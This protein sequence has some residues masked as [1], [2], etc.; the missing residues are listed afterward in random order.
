MSLVFVGSCTA[1]HH[2]CFKMVDMLI[3]HFEMNMKKLNP[4]AKPYEPKKEVEE[5]NA[6]EEVQQKDKR[7]MQRVEGHDFG[8]KIPSKN[9]NKR[10][11]HGGATTTTTCVKII[12]R[13]PYLKILKKRMRKT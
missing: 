9:I 5:V 13:V 11:K 10:N 3:H 1:I 2:Q 12:T 6:N 7:V 8:W 4:C